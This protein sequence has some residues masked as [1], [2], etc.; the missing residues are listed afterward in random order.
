MTD[1]KVSRGPNGELGNRS[2]P[3]DDAT[4]AVEVTQWNDPLAERVS[5]T[6][7]RRG[8]ASFRT[9][10]LGRAGSARLEFRATLGAKLF[11]LVFVLC[12]LGLA[13]HLYWTEIR[14][15]GLAF[16]FGLGIRAF[17]A[18]LFVAAGV[19]SWRSMMTPIVFDA[20]RGVYWKAEGPSG[21][22]RQA[23]DR[24]MFH[25]IHALQLVSERVE[26]RRSHFWSHELNL[27]LP[28][29]TRILVVDHGNIEALRTEANQLARFLGKP[30]W[31]VSRS[32]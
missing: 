24:V 13:T 4:T 12:G 17:G 21:S 18:L 10:V 8:G 11:S 20:S 19:Y 16:E 22:E 23:K 31:D 29:A 7:L 25:E 6:P 26:S 2:E 1:A 30:V 9:H 14:V 32:G 15:D 27:V 3:S 28:D 5:W